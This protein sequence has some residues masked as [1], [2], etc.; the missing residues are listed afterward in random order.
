MRGGIGSYL[1][2]SDYTYSKSPAEGVLKTNLSCHWKL[3][4]NSNNLVYVNSKCTLYYGEHNCWLAK[5]KV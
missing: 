4:G 3:A 5:I 1:R 2:L